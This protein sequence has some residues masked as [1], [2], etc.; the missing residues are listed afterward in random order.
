MRSFSPLAAG[1]VIGIMAYAQHDAGAGETPPT[2]LYELTMLE[3][4]PSIFQGNTVPQAINDDG[5]IVGSSLDGSLRNRPVLWNNSTAPVDL[6]IGEGG[7]VD[8]AFD[9][10][11][12]GLI[13]GRLGAGAAVWTPQGRIDLSPLPGHVT[14]TALGVNDA[15]TAVGTSTN[16]SGN[17]HAVVWPDI[18]AV[19]GPSEPVEL[20]S[21]DGLARTTAV[22]ISENGVISG[23]D[24]SGVS[25]FRNGVFWSPDETG[26][27]LRVLDLL[28]GRPNDAPSAAG[29]ISDNGL[30]LAG[31][32]GLTITPSS[33]RNHSVRW[34]P[35]G[36]ITNLGA[37][38]NQTGFGIGNDANDA[39][40]VVGGGELTFGD[41][42]AVLYDNGFLFDLNFSVVNPVPNFVLRNA[43]S[44]NNSGQIV[45]T[46]DFGGGDGTTNHAWLLTPVVAF[47]FGDIDLNGVVNIDD[48]DNM[49]A[50]VIAGTATPPV[51]ERADLTFD[52]VLDG[53]DLQE[54]VTLLLSQ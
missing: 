29:R 52:G 3:K 32:A 6:A 13:A 50:V 18:F 5:M 25:P 47:L 45:G 42:R 20:P 17:I 38:N 53:R 21:I 30:F 35:D 36:S 26:Y 10:S 31:T 24:D 33:H 44:I 49:A 12:S 7:S 54:F 8:G 27:V 34:A 22:S 51:F 16:S 37:L 23:T 14:A 2:P 28:S 48:V 9:V 40:L 4:L 39:G 43:R 15:G 41:A 46:G 11:P 19:G 1:L